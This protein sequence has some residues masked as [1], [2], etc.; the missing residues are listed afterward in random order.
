M[1]RLVRAIVALVVGAVVLATGTVVL[2]AAVAYSAG[3]V[4]VRVHE[5]KPGGTNL[6]IPVPAALV[7]VGLKFIPER[8]LQRVSERVGP[9]LPAIRVLA[10]ELARTPDATLV[11][12]KSRREHVRV[13]KRGP[14]LIIDVESEDESIHVSFPLYL[15]SWVALELEPAALPS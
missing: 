3:T 7:P 5:K 1:L 9:W 6:F 13:V 10:E 15:L 2:A 4:T 8:K 12:V 11:E 14:K